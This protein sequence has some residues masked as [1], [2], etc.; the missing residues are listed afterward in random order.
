MMLSGFVALLP[1]C[2]TPH[3]RAGVTAATD[4]QRLDAYLAPLKD[5]FARADGDPRAL[6]ILSPT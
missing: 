4:L 6:A 5:W 2:R 1:S 3:D